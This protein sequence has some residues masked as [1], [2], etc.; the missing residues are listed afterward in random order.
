[1][2]LYDLPLE[3]IDLILP[4]VRIEEQRLLTFLEYFSASKTSQ[5][6]LIETRFFNEEENVKTGS[7]FWCPASPWIRISPEFL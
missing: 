3:R 1:M 5:F 6:S 7:W 4:S 2:I